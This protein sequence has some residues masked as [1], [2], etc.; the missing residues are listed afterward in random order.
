[1]ARKTAK[2]DELT[3]IIEIPVA[4]PTDSAYRTRQIHAKLTQRQ[5]DAARVLFDGL[6]AQDATLANG[7]HV[8]T[9]A[10][11]IKWL[12]EQIADGVQP[13]TAA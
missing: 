10:D 5:A 6:Y 12:L 13:A 3:V 11:A 1:M 9:P 2:H 4:V 7:H 8:D